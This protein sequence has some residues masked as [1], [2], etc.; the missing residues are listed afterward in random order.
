MSHPSDRP[1]TVWILN[2]SA[3]PRDVPGISRHHDLGAELVR[4]GNQVV[5]FSSS[6]DCYSHKYTRQV[7]SSGWS[8]E[9]VNGIKWVWLWTCAY[10]RNDARR[11]LGM[12]QF[13][14][15]VERVAIRLLRLHQLPHPD[16]IIGSTVHPLAAQ[17]GANLA[18]AL[19][20]PFV[21]EVRDL[22][23]ETLIDMDAL[24]RNG[25]P[26]RL[27][28]GLEKRLCR[29]SSGII[30]VP[31]HAGDYFFQRGVPRE[32]IIWIPNSVDLERYAVP[33]TKDRLQSGTFNVIYTGA[34]G[35]NDGMRNAIEA[36]TELE[37]RGFPDIR[38]SLYG[39]GNE[40]AALRQLAE[41]RHLASIS[42]C[43]RVPKDQVPA[44]LNAADA[45][46]M[47]WLSLPLYRY[48]VSP[49]KLGDYM[50]ASKPII[51]SSDW[52]ITA[53]DSSG[54]A[55]RC[56]AEDPSALADAVLQMRAK[57]DVER[58]AMGRAGRV[59][60]ERVLGIRE[61]GGRLEAGLRRVIE[62]HAIADGTVSD[63]S[64]QAGA[65]RNPS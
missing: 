6:F 13:K 51:C 34:L 17:A 16:V 47:C 30:I 46:L 37:R 12:I 59:Y 14:S 22:W 21:F 40:K 5:V 23:P 43:E 7:P 31:D 45:T 49:N 53:L 27:L 3:H 55:I 32:N 24:R 38:L 18:R 10:F 20:V 28:A 50:A 62:G 39:D 57:S 44:I 52:P 54:C 4:R 41:S 29:E 61:V 26:A 19:G 25:L 1:F 64:S 15:R 9:L 36:W 8:I 42:F 63:A 65:S 2:H 56:A 48:G 60:A 11:V 58:A 35:A 33:G